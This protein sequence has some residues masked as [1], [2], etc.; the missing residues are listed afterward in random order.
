MPQL[1][2]ATVPTTVAVRFAETD[3]MGITHHSAYIVW[4]E[5]GRVAWMDAVG[6]PYTE[7]SNGGH[8]FAV[9]GINV[10]YRA[11]ST[12]GDTLR[13]DTT[14]IELR[15][16]KVRFE[17]EIRHAQSNELLITASSDHICVD[18]DGRMA[19]IPANF[20]ERIEQGAAGFRAK[21]IG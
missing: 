10:A 12:F 13:I 1:P 17:Y 6:V 11:S 7:I 19:K 20:L 16:R 15:S 8:H 4:F 3:L 14:L 18:L 9:T 5:M 2:L 21:E